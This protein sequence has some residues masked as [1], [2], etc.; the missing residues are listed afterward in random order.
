MQ[1]IL[2]G[3]YNQSQKNQLDTLVGKLGD[4]Q[5]MWDFED[6]NIC[7]S[8][9]VPLLIEKYKL[10]AI[11]LLHD[12]KGKKRCESTSLLFPF[13]DL[14]QEGKG[15]QYTTLLWDFWNA[16]ATCGLEKLLLVFADEWEEDTLVRIE[17]HSFGDLTKRL[18]DYYIWCD[19]HTN[20]SRDLYYTE[21][22]DFP[23]ILEL[24][25]N[26]Q[27]KNHFEGLKV[28][29]IESTAVMI[30]GL[31][32]GLEKKILDGIV[33]NLD[34]LQIVWDLEQY[35]YTSPNAV[36]DL[37]E[38]FKLPFIG[39]L[40]GEIKNSNLTSEPLVDEV[41]DIFLGSQKTPKLFTFLDALAKSN[42]EKMVL[43]FA[44]EYMEYGNTTIKLEECSF[45]KVKQRLNTTFV[46]RKEY[47]DLIT[48]E[49][50]TTNRYPLVLELKRDT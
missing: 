43:M 40:V 3:V 16:L 22:Y 7:A 46:W 36:K 19:L 23:L 45:E 25:S 6:C 20:L 32:N 17:K 41:T 12:A 26:A 21:D 50:T 8:F 31:Y 48:N 49:L 2:L 15:R 24:E 18:D 13:R 42:I 28:A 14:Y 5:I 47:V 27:N 39:I 29:K 38:D 44:H 1:V 33:A 10:F 30:F 34:N 37:K 4:L 9:G 35:S 11:G